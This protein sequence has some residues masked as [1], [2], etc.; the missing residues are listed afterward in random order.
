MSHE[1]HIENAA[2][3]DAYARR[4][5]STLLAG[6]RATVLALS[7]E[8]G[9]GKTTF[10]K[11]LAVALGVTE[12]I[13][14]P[15]FVIMKT[16]PL[17]N[18]A[19]ARLIHID[20]YRLKSAEE[21]RVLGFDALASDRGNLICIEWPERLEGILPADAVPLAFSYSEGDTRIVTY[22][23]KETDAHSNT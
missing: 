10:V 7:G 22:G 23:K 16:Y 14:S 13:T 20:A 4:V 6:V 5:L 9:A 12:H 21:L 8:L 2:A 18:Q 3:F 17:K 15:T 1:S 11:A 19:Y